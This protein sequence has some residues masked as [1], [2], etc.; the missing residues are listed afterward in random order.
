LKTKREGARRPLVIANFALTADGKVSTRKFTPTGFTSQTDKRRL[1]EIRS[2][3][4]ALLAGARTVAADL[5]SMRISSAALRQRRERTG[6][7][8][9]PFRV[10]VSNSRA[11]N[12]GWKV[13]QGGGSQVVAFS[14]RRMPVG[15]RATISRL[16]DLWIFDS[17]R[18]D[19]ARTLHILR[20]DYEVRTLVCEGGPRLF[21]ELLEIGAIDELRLTWAP[22]V[23]GG[24]RAPTLTGVPGQSLLRTLRCRLKEIEIL[25]E[26]CFL[27]YELLGSKLL[28]GRQRG[29]LSSS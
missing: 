16:A 14:T 1:Q 7:S 13:F 18:V 6:R 17:S 24:A 20:R 28:P 25:G 3:G 19:L 10:I 2:L 27:R 26:E 23:F 4:D 22:W 29:H 8:R 9:E 11:M 21:R 5:M 12:P 15:L